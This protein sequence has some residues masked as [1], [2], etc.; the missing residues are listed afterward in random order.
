MR[1][2]RPGPDA[3]TFIYITVLLDMT[4]L[5]IISPV[6]PQRI[7]ELTGRAVDD[8]AVVGGQLYSSCA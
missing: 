3:L 2:R 8:A 5:G 6:M 7:G 1:H 4:G